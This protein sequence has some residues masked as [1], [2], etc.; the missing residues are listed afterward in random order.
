MRK[1][2]STRLGVVIG[3][4]FLLAAC[5]D[6]I[7]PGGDDGPDASQ[8]DGDIPI[9]AP[10][11]TEPP[12]EATIS[13]TLAVFDVA[14]TDPTAALV[15][16]V[17]GGAIRMSFNDLT[18]GGGEV[19]FSGG[20]DAPIGSCLITKFDADSLPNPRL[21]AGTVTV[22]PPES[23]VASAL[24]KTVGPC[25]LNAAFGE[26]DPYV[27]ISHNQTG[28]TAGAQD[29]NALQPGSGLVA[30]TLAV[31]P[32]D[33]GMTTPTQI[34]GAARG[35]GGLPANTVQITTTAP[36]GYST[37][38]FVTIVGMTPTTF[39]T[40][41]SPIQVNGAN[42]FLFAQAGANEVGTGFGTASVPTGVIVGSALVIN[43][44][45]VDPTFNSGTSAFPIIGQTSAN[46]VLVINSAPANDAGAAPATVNYTIL[47]GFSPVPAAGANANFLGGSTATAPASVRIQK[48]ANAV[49]PAIDFTVDV[50]GEQTRV[51]ISTTTR[52]AD[53]V[54]ATTTADHGFLAGATVTVAGVADA[55]FNGTFVV[56]SAPTATSFTYAD[57]DPAGAST[58]GTATKAGFTL[59][60]GSQLAH[61]FPQGTATAVNYS[62]DNDTA[63]AGDDTCGDESTTTLKAMIISGSAS[64][65]SV[66]GIFPFQMPTEVPGTDEW[67]EWQCAFL[68]SKT[69]DMPVA[70]V[71]EIID[72]GPTRIE[73]QVLFVAGT[74]L[75]DGG[76]VNQMRLLV[77][78]ALA[79]HQTFCPAAGNAVT[80]FGT[81]ACPACNDGVDNDTDGMTDF[82]A[83]SG[84]TSATDSSE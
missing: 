28:A 44:F 20:V 66:A 59:D 41:G 22:G 83:D 33:F 21:D 76:G 8:I 60:A 81:P 68:L 71:Q 30:Y 24:L 16:G 13:G 32:V 34:A 47:N 4:S 1:T 79:G 57:V 11:D 12:P 26:P 67:L 39:N 84:C 42:T 17:R 55:T 61:V 56:A 3:A 35:L 29:L 9:D 18:V 58:G 54:T 25:N 75:D 53:V 23:P 63:G 6:N 19:V 73:Q 82:P 38:M 80:G 62:C 40:V 70:A 10:P 78:H 15:G 45:T 31:P 5:G 72:F 36:H 51:G 64:K 77:G 7:L 48:A 2:I 49:W 27:C 65:K 74:L 14:L 69:A 43:G 37:G 52:A 46:T 50:P